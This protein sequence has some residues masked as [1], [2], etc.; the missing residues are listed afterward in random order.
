MKYI[1]P[2]TK[3][4]QVNAQS[5]LCESPAPGPQRSGELGTMKVKNVSSWD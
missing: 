4:L 2:E 5:F 1:T 3:S